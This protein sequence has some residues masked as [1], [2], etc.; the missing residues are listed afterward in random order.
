[1]LKPTAASSATLT[2]G[3]LI[4]WSKSLE[5]SKRFSPATLCRVAR[6]LRV[7]P[8]L[9]SLKFSSFVPPCFELSCQVLGDGCWP[10][11]SDLEGCFKH[12]VWHRRW[13]IESVLDLRRKVAEVFFA[14]KG[15]HTSTTPVLAPA[16]SAG[17]YVAVTSLP[18]CVCGG[19]LLELWQQSLWCEAML[20]LARTFSLQELPW[21]WNRPVRSTTGSCISHCLLPARKH[22]SAMQSSRTRAGFR[23][24]SSTP[25][26]EGMG[27][28]S[29]SWYTDS[30]DLEPSSNFMSV[31][32]PEFGDPRTVHPERTLLVYLCEQGFFMSGD[33]KVGLNDAV[34]WPVLVSLP[35]AGDER[36]AGPQKMSKRAKPGLSDRPVLLNGFDDGACVALLVG[37]ALHRSFFTSEEWQ[38]G[39]EVGLLRQGVAV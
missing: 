12:R 9:G 26:L 14:P 5:S 10:S 7:E 27:S 11:H 28:W 23:E 21:R 8:I 17:T 36:P 20:A 6:H 15:C 29:G 22:F 18:S 34:Y 39:Q 3:Y 4:D 30:W 2:S 37:L 35:V 1:M 25:R 24:R 13:A 38:V 31:S 32:V 33:C 16:G 19:D